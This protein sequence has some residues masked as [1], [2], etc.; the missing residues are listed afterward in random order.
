M[1]IIGYLAIFFSFVIGI[2]FGGMAAFL[3]R[4]MVINRQLRIAQ[5]RASKMVAEAR[6]EAKNVLQEAKQEVR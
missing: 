5:R 6:L 1:E 2:I 4:R 3:S